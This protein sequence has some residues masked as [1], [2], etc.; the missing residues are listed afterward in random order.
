MDSKSSDTT[1]KELG[2]AFRLCRYKKW[3]ER[4][5]NTEII[6]IN[7]GIDNKPVKL[8]TV[9]LNFHSTENKKK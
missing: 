6:E 4:D 8:G 3:R 2:A 5:F 1:L 9:K 7:S